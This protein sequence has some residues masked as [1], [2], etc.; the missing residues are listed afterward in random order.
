MNHKPFVFFS[1]TMTSLIIWGQYIM[2]CL[3]IIHQA[4]PRSD[5]DLA[6]VGASAFFPILSALSQGLFS[7]K[8]Q[9]LFFIF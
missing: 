9:F 4:L 5:I 3:G 8:F 2:K 6:S 7:L 1:E